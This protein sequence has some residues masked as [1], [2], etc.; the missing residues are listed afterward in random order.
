M[1]QQQYLGSR[2]CYSTKK[3]HEARASK[4][5]GSERGKTQLRQLDTIQLDRDTSRKQN[6][7]MG[8]AENNK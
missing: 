1:E 3:E 5:F 4:P 6:I 8:A 7:V 2:I